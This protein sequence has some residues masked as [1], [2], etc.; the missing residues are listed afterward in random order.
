MTRHHKVS[1]SQVLSGRR[2]C[3]RSRNYDHDR[4][5][6]DRGVGHFCRELVEH[7]FAQPSVQA[8]PMLDLPMLDWNVLGRSNRDWR[9]KICDRDRMAIGHQ[10][11]VCRWL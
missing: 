8:L 3:D 2:L 1:E 9:S 6:F 7:R 11:Q 4:K 5:N 10:M